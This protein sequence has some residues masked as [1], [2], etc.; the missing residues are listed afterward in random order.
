MRGPLYIYIM[1][2]LFTTYK[3]RIHCRALQA[4]PDTDCYGHEDPV[5]GL[6]YSGFGPDGPGPGPLHQGGH[7]DHCTASSDAVSSDAA[8]I[9]AI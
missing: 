5:P 2:F 1:L 4:V 3:N 6:R 7:P 8:E 9:C